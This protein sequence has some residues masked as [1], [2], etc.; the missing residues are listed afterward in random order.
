M[1]FQA[2]RKTPSGHLCGLPVPFPCGVHSCKPP[3]QDCLHW[4]PPVSSFSKSAAVKTPQI[5]CPRCPSPPHRFGP[6]D[7]PHFL[8]RRQRPKHQA[9]PAGAPGPWVPELCPASV[10]SLPSVLCSMSFLLP[11]QLALLSCVWTVCRCP[12][13]FFAGLLCSYAFASYLKPPCPTKLSSFALA[14][15][16]AS[17][18]PQGSRARPVHP[19]FAV[20]LSTHRQKIHLSSRLQTLFVFTLLSSLFYHHLQLNLSESELTASLPGSVIRDCIANCSET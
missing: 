12:G 19:A 17:A 14:L 8:G 10:L 20:P 15:S 7:L 13:L 4:V 5:H 9:S 2:P 18:L 1:F 16:D 11:S 3:L 6:S